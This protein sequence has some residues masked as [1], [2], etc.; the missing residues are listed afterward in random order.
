MK[1]KLK[2]WIDYAIYD[3]IDFIKRS[4]QRSWRNDTVNVNISNTT[5][6]LEAKADKRSGDYEL[7]RV[8]FD[9][10][11]RAKTELY[12]LK[13]SVTEYQ[14]IELLNAI[15]KAVNNAAARAGIVAEV[16]DDSPE[17]SPP[18]A[19][20][21]AAAPKAAALAMDHRLT[22]IEKKLDEILTI[23]KKNYVEGI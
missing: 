2:Y 1:S 4:N 15:L 6:F 7:F 3:L 19:E 13:S 20:P 9:A 12:R 8:Y 5:Q 11:M 18:A 16:P 14:F 21:P 22:A 23:L 10:A 17:D